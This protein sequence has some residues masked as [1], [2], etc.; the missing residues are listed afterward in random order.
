ME[1]TEQ[2]DDFDQTFP[3]TQVLFTKPYV[4][5]QE[6][7]I[8]FEAKEL[9]VH[10][11]TITFVYDF[12]NYT[13]CSESFDIIILANVVSN[14]ELLVYSIDQDIDP[15]LDEMSIPIYADLTRPNQYQ[16]DIES[17]KV[18]VDRSIFLPNSVTG[19]NIIGYD[20]DGD[21]LIISIQKNDV[22]LSE[23]LNELAVLNGIPLLGD[24]KESLVEVTE[25]NIN[26]ASLLSSATFSS[27]TLTMLVCEE[28]GDRLLKAVNPIDL[29]I[30]QNSENIKITTNIIESGKHSILVSDINGNLVYQKD[31][32]RNIGSTN[33]YEFIVDN[34]KLTTGTYFVRLQTPQRNLVELVQ[35]IR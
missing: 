19:G 29:N 24:K 15:S 32:I 12:D 18:S 30:T 13:D 27:S 10:S 7:D 3:Q 16:F 23:S 33:N 6:F 35:V 21:N 34:S 4:N 8:E 9:G 31:W 25:L 2:G 17:M 28:G 11:S 5:P 22:T 14:M 20:Y 26:P 1:F